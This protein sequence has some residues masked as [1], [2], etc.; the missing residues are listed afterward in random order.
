MAQQVELGDAGLLVDDS[1]RVGNAK[2][3]RQQR[4]IRT[5]LRLVVCR[6]SFRAVRRVNIDGFHGFL[7][8][9]RVRGLVGTQTNKHRLPHVARFGPSGKRHFGQQLWLDPVRLARYG[10][11]AVKRALVGSQ[12]VELA[13][14][15]HQL[16]LVEAGAHIAGVL[17]LAVLVMH[18]EHQCTQTVA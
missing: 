9:D 17:Q 10:G 5:R 4:I 15:I 6:M 14:Q 11:L 16:L 8:C 18:P 1:F 7:P 3:C 12:F 2:R 13:A